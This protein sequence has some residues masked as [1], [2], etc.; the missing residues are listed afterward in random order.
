[1]L[2][3]IRVDGLSKLYRVAARQQG[4][5]TLRESSSEAVWAPIERIRQSFQPKAESDGAEG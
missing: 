1:M 5:K 2:P 4:Y 3:A